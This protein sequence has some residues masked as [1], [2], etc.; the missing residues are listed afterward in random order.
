MRVSPIIAIA[1]GLIVLSGCG[2]RN[3]S[4]SKHANMQGTPLDNHKIGVA[5]DTRM[6]EI[7]I[8]PVNN[9]LS[10]RDQE[11]IRRFVGEYTKD[12]H[13]AFV[14]SPPRGGSNPQLANEA[15]RLARQIAWESGI[16]Y[17]DIVGQPYVAPPHTHAPLIL[18][19]RAYNIIPPNCESLATINLAD[20]SSNN[21]Q[22]SFG[23]AVRYNQAKM[24]AN[25][26]D[27]LGERPLDRG[28]P[29]SQVA[30]IE[31]YVSQ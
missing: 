25:P 15:V 8:D 22:R 30:A 26:A 1:V 16:N 9:T 31:K 2:H 27:V 21:P 23:C 5:E 18:A 11:L 17:D 4:S 10:S 24:I 20:V 28:L 3:Q 19:F 13:G 14:M 7:A 6:L 12:G 29:Q